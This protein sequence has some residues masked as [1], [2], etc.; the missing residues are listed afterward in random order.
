MSSVSFFVMSHTLTLGIILGGLVIIVNFNILQHTI[1]RA[2]SSEGVMTGKMVVIFKYYMRLLA[3][4]I[5]IYVLIT[6]GLVDPIGLAI[7]LSTVV[8]SIVS[9]GIS[10]AWKTF[11]TEAT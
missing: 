1:Q 5:I 9:F 3:L 2:F 10:R 6:H 7:G 4:G 11:S 8:I